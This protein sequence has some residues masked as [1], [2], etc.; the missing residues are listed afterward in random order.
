MKDNFIWIILAIIIGYLFFTDGSSLAE[1]IKFIIF[2]NLFLAL[3]IILIGVIYL[4]N[5]K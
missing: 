4:T 1:N 3:I 5:K 2:N